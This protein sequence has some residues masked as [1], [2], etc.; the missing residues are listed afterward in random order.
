MV[1]ARTTSRWYF[2]IAMGR[3]AGHLA[4]GAG[5]AAG[6]PVILIPEEFPERPIQLDDVV[7][8]LEGA[9]AKAYRA[10]GEITFDG[11]YYRSDIGK[12]GLPGRERPG[13]RPVRVR[14]GVRAAEGDDGPVLE[15]ER[16]RSC[17]PWPVSR[18]GQEPHSG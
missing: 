10:V 12:K 7:R 14:R 15:L 1:D 8:T 6:A 16:P 5:K 3:T 17:R 9:I 18:T 13:G 2:V 11:A 4:L